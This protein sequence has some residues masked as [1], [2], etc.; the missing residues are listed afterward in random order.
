MFLVGVL[1]VKECPRGVPE[2]H[3]LGDAAGGE[4]VRPS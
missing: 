3:V 2:R 4:G 1:V